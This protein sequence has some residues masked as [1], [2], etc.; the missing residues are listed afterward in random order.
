MNGKNPVLWVLAGLFKAVKIVVLALVW[1]IVP[2]CLLTK[3]R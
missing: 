3:N 2:G 1:I